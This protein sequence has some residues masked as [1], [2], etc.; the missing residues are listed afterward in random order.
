M[1]GRKGGRRSGDARERVMEKKNCPVFNGRT[2]L[3]PSPT[4]SPRS[5]EM[6]PARK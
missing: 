4:S 2:T 6:I 5:Q 1:M 3:P